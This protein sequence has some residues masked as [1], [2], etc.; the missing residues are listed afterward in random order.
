MISVPEVMG[1]VQKNHRV[2]PVPKQWQ[3]LY[4]MLPKKHRKSARCQP[5]LPLILAGWSKSTPEEKMAHL[6]E[7]LEWASR[8][9]CLEKVHSFLSELPEEDWYHRIRKAPRPSD[10]DEGLSGHSA[11]GDVPFVTCPQC[12]VRVKNMPGHLRKV[13]PASSSA[14]VLPEDGRA[15][16]QLKFTLST[17]PVCHQ[18]VRN[19]SKHFTITGH[20]DE[21]ATPS[22]MAIRVRR[23]ASGWLCPYCAATLP[24]QA[25]LSSHLVGSH[26]IRHIK[27][28]IPE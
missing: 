15:N 26:G 16:S 20:G 9:D 17:C 5:P 8:N 28:I 18:L 25:Q 21:K 24:T 10:L 1:E 11:H 27:R 3:I 19:L 14:Q 13:H 12:G 6:R 23:A 4:D 22:G 2:C 7:H